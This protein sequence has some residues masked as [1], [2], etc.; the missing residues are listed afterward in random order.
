MELL[1]DKTFWVKYVLNDIKYKFNHKVLHNSTGNSL[2]NVLVKDLKGLS[3]DQQLSLLLNHSTWI[4]TVGRIILE[5]VYLHHSPYFK[6]M[7]QTTSIC[8][9]Q[10]EG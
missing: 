2:M 3:V 4:A 1:F 7:C 6:C 5:H 10:R 8:L 9:L